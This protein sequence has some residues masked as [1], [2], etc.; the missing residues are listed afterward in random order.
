[1]SPN[2][3]AGASALAAIVTGG[4]SGIGQATTLRL[5]STGYRVRAFD[6]D[7]EGLDRTATMADSPNL[8][9]AVVDLANVSHLEQT[10]RSV[11]DDSGVPDLLVNNAGVGV[12]GTV[13]ETSVADWD[14]TVAVNLS[15]VFHLC[16]LLVPPM[17]ERGRGVIVNVAS[18]GGLVG[19]GNRAAYC[20]SKGGVIGLTRALAADHAGQGLRI[21][22]ICPGT[23]E[24][25]W[26]DRI[27]EDAEDPEGARAAMAA[28]QLDGRMG[29]AEEVASGIVFLA[30]DDARFVNGSAFIMDGGLT[31]V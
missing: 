20:A 31:A 25:A 26:V 30:S 10:V 17:V 14:R 7:V 8:V 13:G 16:R 15:A 27:I 11:L 4:G 29:T 19:L 28:R 3:H 6:V 23:V 22:A 18:I 21:N 12:A 24:T 2:N 9:T 1:M 5:L